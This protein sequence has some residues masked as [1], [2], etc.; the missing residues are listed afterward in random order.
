[1]PSRRQKRW[2]ALKAPG[3]GGV[4]KRREEK[5]MRT[6]YTTSVVTI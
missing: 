5:K 6:V 1:M 2:R 4:G 3:T